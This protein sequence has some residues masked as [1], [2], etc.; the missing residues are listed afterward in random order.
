[1]RKSKAFNWSAVFV[2][3][4]FKSSLSFSYELFVTEFVSMNGT[5]SDLSV[6]MV[7]ALFGKNASFR[8]MFF[9]PVIMCFVVFSFIMKRRKV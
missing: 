3:A 6:V 2:E 4:T 7:V 5:H 1:M 9:A 8:V